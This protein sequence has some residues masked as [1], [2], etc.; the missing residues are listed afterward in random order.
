MADKTAY[1]LSEDD[2]IKLRDSMAY[3]ES[4]RR[5]KPITDDESFDSTAPDVYLVM[6]PPEGISAATNMT[7]TGTGSPLESTP[8]F[9]TCQVW[10]FLPDEE[11]GT[12]PRMAVVEDLTVDVYNPFTTAL[13]GST[14][15]P[16]MK[17]KYGIWVVAC[18]PVQ[19]Q[20][21]ISISAF[22]SAGTLFDTTLLKIPPRTSYEG[23]INIH[24]WLS[25]ASKIAGKLQV[26]EYVNGATTTYDSQP[27]AWP[28]GVLYDGPL[29][30]TLNVEQ[31][32]VMSFTNDDYVYTKYI[33][34]TFVDSG[35]SVG[36][37]TLYQ[38]AYQ[39]VSVNF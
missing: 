17:D 32:G 36:T 38:V 2:V 25:A 29:M 11:A 33:T 15:V 37:Y 35:L 4:I 16:V 14:F 30:S 34:F 7:L 1:V 19:Q 27:V 5:N 13:S 8:G 23:M 3:V 18:A 6:T 28:S 24:G 21:V 26:T 10:S 22:A 20:T 12:T 9:A 39:P 31:V